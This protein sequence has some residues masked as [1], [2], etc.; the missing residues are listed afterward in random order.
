MQNLFK[1][2]KK[3]KNILVFNMFSALFTDNFAVFITKGHMRFH[4]D[5]F[6]SCK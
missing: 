4:I 2:Q 5:N 3:E 1:D 6:T